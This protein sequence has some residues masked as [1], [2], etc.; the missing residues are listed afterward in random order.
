M[1]DTAYEIGRLCLQT[2]AKPGSIV[3]EIGSL[4]VNGS[5]RDA[6]PD[7]VTYLG[8][9]FE[10]GNGVDI[11]ARPGEPFPIRDG[12]CDL[13]I[14]TSQMEHDPKFWKTFLEFCRLTK[15]GGTIYISSP[16]N[17]DYHTFPLDAWRFYPDAG[18]ALQDWATENGETLLLLES[19]TASR[20]SDQ[21]NDFVAVFHKGAL[22]STR[23]AYLSDH[24]PSY[25]VRQLG[26][27]TLIRRQVRSED[28]LLVRAKD[29]EIARLGREIEE[30]KE[31]LATLR[32]AGTERVASP[33]P[34]RLDP[35]ST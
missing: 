33:E 18:L 14:S 21:W 6:C 28:A 34:A 7:G 27:D 20:R 24:V 1:H 30:L 31:Q 23:G 35:G 9:D 2:Y 22:P 12:F 8:L 15:D 17:G 5:L 13:L 26:S 29:E 4:D 16:S 19:F 25:N 32:T 10:Q 11:F 3:L